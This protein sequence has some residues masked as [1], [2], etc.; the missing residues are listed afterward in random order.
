MNFFESGKMYAGCNYWASHAGIYMWRDW[1]ESVVDNDFKQLAELKI[2]LVRVFP[3]WPDFQPIET[4]YGYA[5]AVEGYSIDGGATLLDSFDCGM[6]ETM[7]L[8]F[9]KLLE[10]A[11]KYNISLIPSLI[12]GWMSGRLFVPPALVGRN[13]I[14][15]PLAIKWEI[16]FIKAFV[17]RFKYNKAIAA[18]CLGNECN[19]MSPVESAEQAWLWQSCLSNAFKSEDPSRQVISGMHSQFTKTE[20]KWTLQDCGDTCDI[21]TTHPYASPEYKTDHELMNTIKPLIHPAAQTLYSAAISNKPCFIE[22]TGTYGQMYGNEEMNAKYM[23]GAIFTAW[24]HN[25]LSYLWWIGYDQGSLI[26]HPF[27]YNNRASNYG[28]FREDRSLKSVGKVIKEYNEFTENFGSL[29]E[30]LV[31]AVCIVT[32]HQ[33]TWEAAGASFILAKQARMELTFAYSL[34]EL[35]ESDVYIIPN[36]HSASPFSAEYLKKLMKRVENGATLYI[37]LGNGFP[38][39]LN[40]DFGFELISRKVT[41]FVESMNLDGDELEVKSNVIYDIVL[42][43][44]ALSL[45][46]NR[47][48]KDV[49]IKSTYG[50]GTVYTL[51]YSLEGYL[52]Q[53]MDAFTNEK[54]Y[55]IYDKLRQSIKNQRC[56]CCEN[57]MIGITEHPLNENERYIVAVNYGED[58]AVDFTL[59]QG[60]KLS[61][62]CRGEMKESLK[63]DIANCKTVVFKIKRQKDKEYGF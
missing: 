31:D 16:K 37:S 62:V 1:D 53:K 41:N 51:M 21:I 24:A 13:L 39:N 25:C 7:L 42:K 2:K 20:G 12:T 46:K 27:G 61:C 35:P 50:K 30:R 4:I 5:G 38:K 55:K 49:F 3:L 60:W 18:W 19:C 6:N 48:G 47:E 36:M 22:E 45:A 63:S 44:N 57:R 28:L 11:Q 10:T 17:K 32:P 14:T 58:A 54:H 34:D 29:P 15:D 52:Y 40:K 9:E 26:Y 56:V 8:H 59:K 23:E 43:S 33:N